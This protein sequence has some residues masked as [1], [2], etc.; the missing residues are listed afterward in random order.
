MGD[1]WRIPAAVCFWLISPF[2]VAIITTYSGVK[3]SRCSLQEGGDIS[4]MAIID[5]NTCDEITGDESA[6]TISKETTERQ[7]LQTEQ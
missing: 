3:F 7:L 1:H 4:P 5:M 6:L 2:C